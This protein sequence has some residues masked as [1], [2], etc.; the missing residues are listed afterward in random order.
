MT[1]VEFSQGLMLAGTVR[2][3]S[4]GQVEVIAEG[5]STEIDQ[6]VK[7]LREHFGTFVRTVDQ[8]SVPVKGLTGGIRVSH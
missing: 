6:L 4:D 1:T 7:R 8:T 5:E 3:L 2:N